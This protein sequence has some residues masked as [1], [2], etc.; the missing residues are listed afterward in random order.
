MTGTHYTQIRDNEAF[1]TAVV[2]LVEITDDNLRAVSAL[3]THRHQEHF[4]API[5]RSLAQF[6]F[7]PTHN[8]YPV[9]PRTTTDR[10]PGRHRCLRTPL[11]GDVHVATPA[12]ERTHM[13][14]GLGTLLVIILLILFLT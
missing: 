2:E 11:Q 7:P 4:V 8:G 13:Y 9:V 1:Q 14:I 6:G 5:S 3:A 12:A 10:R